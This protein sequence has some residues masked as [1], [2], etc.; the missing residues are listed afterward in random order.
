MGIASV[1]L[2]LGIQ[3][4]LTTPVEKV[5]VADCTFGEVYA[6]RTTDCKMR[7]RNLG[8]EGVT[9]R[10]LP[11]DPRDSVS[12][13]L[14][15][16]P[17]GSSV[18]V[19]LQMDIGNDSGEVRRFFRVA[20]IDSDEKAY[21][22]S[23]TGFAMSVL[24]APRPSVDFG[25]V[26]I[27]SSGATR[28]VNL[29]SH[30]SNRFRV[31]R[32]LEAPTALNAKVIDGNTI[33]LKVRDDAEWGLVEGFVKVALDNPLQD[34]AWIAV[35]ADIQGE[36]VPAMNPVWLGIVPAGQKREATIQLKSRTG[37]DF[38]IG[39]VDLGDM[40]GRADIVACEP[41]TAGCKAIHLVIAESEPAGSLRKALSVDFPQF[42]QKLAVSIWGVLQAKPAH[43]AGKNPKAESSIGPAREASIGGDSGLPRPVL[44][45]VDRGSAAGDSASNAMPF[46]KWSVADDSGVHGYQVFRAERAD[47][48]FLLQNESLIKAKGSKDSINA[49]EWRD[50]SAQP[51]KTYWYY[52]GAVGKSGEKR[53]LSQP[54]RKVVD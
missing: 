24:D 19:K 4:A 28:I 53:K 7:I 47:G 40:Q 13:D 51:G 11:S 32:V 12:E 14:V 46:L 6:F 8:S 44:G 16:V 43:S 30:D 15:K 39:S 49:Y 21:F 9:L 29:N 23:A 54:Q 10:V 38:Q 22:A 20:R 3:A 33:E 45:G 48:P 34:E 18:D 36:V 52:I 25:M 37:R 2:L 35:K 31:M 5:E 42:K 17:A 41:A 50:P 27:R 26:S 1:F